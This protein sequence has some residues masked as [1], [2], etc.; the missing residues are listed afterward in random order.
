MSENDPSKQNPSADPSKGPGGSGASP[1]KVYQT[2]E[3]YKASLNRKLANY[4]PKSEL[5][6]ALERVSSFENSLNTLQTENQ[7]LKNEIANYKLGDLKKKI[8]KESGLPSEWIDELRG[9]DEKSIKEHAEALRKKL[10]IKHDTGN[11]VPPGNTDTNVTESDV[12]N[13][14]LLGMANGGYGYTGR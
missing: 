10:G 12:M 9:S 1:F 3:Q 8:G 7:G 11:P 5:Q 6:T 14:L 2:E 4:V 13:G